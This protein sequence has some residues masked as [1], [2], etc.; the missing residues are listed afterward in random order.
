LSSVIAGLFLLDL[1][2][3]P[4]ALKAASEFSAVCVSFIGSTIIIVKYGVYLA[5]T[6][7]CASIYLYRGKLPFL[8]E[9]PDGG[10]LYAEFGT[11][12]LFGKQTVFLG[13][14]EKRKKT[15]A[16]GVNSLHHKLV[17]VGE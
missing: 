6:V 9:I 10:F 8:S 1:L 4:D 3:I 2:S 17:E 12:L 13:F 14:N 7:A 16:G 11:Y 5:Q 15:V